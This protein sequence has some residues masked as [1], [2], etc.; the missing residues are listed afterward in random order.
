MPRSPGSKPGFAERFSR[1]R[2]TREAVAAIK[3]LRR[4]EARESSDL[5]AGLVA[6]RAR[7]R[8]E[9]QKEFLARLPGYWPIAVGLF[10]GAISPVLKVMA[11]AL[12]HWCMV[13]VFPFVLLAARPEI[14]VGAPITS[15]F[16]AA[17]LFL[18]FPIEGWLARFI[19]RHRTRFSSVVMQVLLFHFLGIAEL[20]LLSSWPYRLLGR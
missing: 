19:L 17:M 14:Q 4:Q 5:E 6:M 15:T 18:Q 10:L 1:A 13:L 12:G 8:A 7:Q 3:S 11:T 20:L 2:L 16:P 9:R